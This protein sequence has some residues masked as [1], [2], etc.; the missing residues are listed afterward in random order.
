MSAGVSDAYAKEAV[1]G[2]SGIIW[3]VVG[4]LLIIA[5]LIYIF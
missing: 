4:V 1:L 3:T 2:R 5:L